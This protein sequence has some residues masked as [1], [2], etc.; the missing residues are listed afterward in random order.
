MRGETGLDGD[1][2]DV[3]TWM[4]VL[5][6]DDMPIRWATEP[7]KPHPGD[8]L[9]GRLV[10]GDEDQLIIDLCGTAAT[11]LLAALAEAHHATGD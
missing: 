11:K 4:N 10:I 9:A 6:T 1:P 3:P 5:I 8:E 7:G 2:R